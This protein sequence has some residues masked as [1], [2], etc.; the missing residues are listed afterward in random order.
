M[1]IDSHQHFWHYNPVDHAWIGPGL[2]AIQRDFLPQH[3]APELNRAGVDGCIAVQAPQTLAETAWLLEL[4]AANPWIVGVVGW[5]DLCSPQVDEQL[6]RFSAQARFRGVRHIVQGEPDDNFLLRPDFMRGIAALGRFDLAYDLLITPR[7]LPAA[8]E[9]VKQFPAQRF[10][11]D[12]IAKPEIKN[13]IL[14]PWAEGLRRLSGFPNV[15]CKLS[16]MVTEADWQAWKAEDFDPYLDHVLDC[17]G[18]ARLMF[19]SDWPVCLLAGSYAQVQQL[20]GRRIER[21]SPAE[22]AQIWGET[23][24]RFYKV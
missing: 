24:R 15:A 1:R 23:A 20:A 18:P 2:E 6:E 22:Q 11:V 19:G 3:L 21:L 14:S 9:L 13:G 7:Q 10:I 5:V 16:G 12:H 17:F 4:A 8:C